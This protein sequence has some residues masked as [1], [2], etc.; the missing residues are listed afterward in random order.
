M[1]PKGKT[2]SK[3]SDAFRRSN[4]FEFSARNAGKNPKGIV[5]R[6]EPAGDPAIYQ[7]I[8][9][10]AFRKGKAVADILVGLDHDGNLRVLVT[11]DG[12]GDGDHATAVYPE[13]AIGE[14]HVE[15]LNIS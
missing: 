6:S 2:R 5:L 13:K 15:E 12:D 11:A 7:E 10:R 14:G 8:A 9:V 4:P 1:K 3:N